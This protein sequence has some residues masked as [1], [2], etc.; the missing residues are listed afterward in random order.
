[1]Q[2]ASE[3]AEAV[4]QR[5]GMGVEEWLFL[6][7]IALH[8]GGVSPG[9]VEGAGAIEADLANA[10][11]AI[12]DRAA[13]SAGEAADAVVV[14]FFVERGGGFADV[15]IEDLTEGGHGVSCGS[16]GLL[17]LDLLVRLCRE[18]ARFVARTKKSQQGRD[19]CLG[20]SL[21][22]LVKARGFGMTPFNLYQN[23]DGI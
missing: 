13:V 22:A 12:G 2:V 14:E 20:R 16:R 17:I 4:G 11:L 7:G 18:N 9:G 8:S 3:H 10:G 6:D 5:S 19:R 21:R 1:M 23:F 15:V